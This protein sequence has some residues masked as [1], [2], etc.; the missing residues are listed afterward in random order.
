MKKI[1]SS[2]RK[3]K[4]SRII[5][6][7]IMIL[8]GAVCLYTVI[9]MGFYSLK[10]NEEIFVTNPF[11]PPIVPQWGNYIKAVTQFDI[12]LYFK[13]SIWVSLAA[14]FL[15]IMFCL[16]F[17]YVVSRVRVRTTKALHSM[18]IAGMFIPIQ[19]V[20]TPLV[21]MVKNLHLTNTLWSLI[22]PYVALSFPFGVM[23]LY[24][25]YRSLPIELEESAYIE[26]AGFCKTYFQIILPQMKSAVSVLI[27]YQFISHWNEFSLALILITKNEL[28]TLP[29]GLAGFYGQ[30]ST[31]WGPVG[32]A[33]VI[34]SFPVIILYVFFSNKVSDAMAFSGMKN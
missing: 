27:I 17:T 4:S 8:Y 13:N 7:T 20:M 14:M 2:E 32:A 1:R 29:L 9:W 33:L 25:F 19:A 30:F 10:N 34:A 26:G 15:G 21:V 23:V 16:M 12:L 18:V 22:V 28:K 24:G 31:D 5:V 3:I 6:Y 11:G